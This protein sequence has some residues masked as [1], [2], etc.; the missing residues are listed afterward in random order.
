MGLHLLLLTAPL[1]SPLHTCFHPSAPCPLLLLQ[2]AQTVLTHLLSLPPPS[3]F[4]LF[5]VPFQG[6]QT[7]IIFPDRMA[8]DISVLFLTLSSLLCDCRD[9]VVVTPSRPSLTLRQRSMYRCPKAMYTRRK[10]SFK[11]L[12]YMTWTLQTLDPRYTSTGMPRPHL[13]F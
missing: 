11:M 7:A 1:R 2:L 10:R 5:F 12:L 9:K 8:V 4:F 3:L 6:Y 13:C